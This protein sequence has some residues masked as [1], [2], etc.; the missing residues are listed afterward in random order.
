MSK[1]QHLA[2]RVRLATTFD[3]ERVTALLAACY[4]T[5]M[6]DHYSADVLAIA[7]PIMTRAQPRL[8]N[9]GTFLVAEAD[10]ILIGCGGWSIETPGSGAIEPNVGHIRHFATHPDMARRGIGRS[11]FEQCLN[12]ARSCALTHFKCFSSLNARGFYAALGFE[13]LEI[14]EVKLGGQVAFQSLLMQASID[15]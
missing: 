11:I 13:A 4:P 6:A 2:Y 15:R 9:S 12:Q 3:E 14:V 5:L 7:L 1:T 8:L 10:Q